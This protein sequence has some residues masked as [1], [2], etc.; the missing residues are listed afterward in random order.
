MSMIIIEHVPPLIVS[1]ITSRTMISILER[2]GAR[3]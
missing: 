1:T 3:L 2:A